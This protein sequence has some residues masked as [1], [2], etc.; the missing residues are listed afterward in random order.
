[1]PLRD[2]SELLYPAVSETIAVLK[3]DP[4]G[5]DAAAAKLAQQYART[6]DR[7]APGK[8]YAYAVRWLGPEL[9]KVLAELGATPAARAAI[10]GKKT[11]APDAKPNGLAAL[12]AARSS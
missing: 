1:M 4:D 9:L 6:I 11:A 5:Q 2:V 12:R 7:A 10:T 3:L 8:D